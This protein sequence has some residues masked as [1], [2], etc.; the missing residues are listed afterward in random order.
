MQAYSDES[1]FEWIRSGRDAR[2]ARDEN[3][4]GNF[5]SLPLPKEFAAYVKIFHRID[6]S[7]EYMDNSLTPREEEIVQIPP[8]TELKTLIINLR[9]QHRG[10]RLKWKE[11]ADALGVPFE[12]EL[13]H[14]WY[15]A[16]L[17]PGCW[18][19]YLYGP[20]EGTL[21]SEECRAIVSDLR[22]LTGNQTCFFRFAEVPFVGTNKQLLFQG[23]LEE[24]E[25]FLNDSAYQFTPE[26]WWP[27]DRNWC[28]CT[29]Y[30]LTFTIVGGSEELIS[31]FLNDNFLEC[32]EVMPSTRID[33]Y[34]PMR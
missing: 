2:T 8:C 6:A 21:K 9:K 18:P 3:W 33:D 5:V 22:P 25:T 24:V 26:Y 29:D 28:L 32:I 30:D 7:Y 31:N 20:D 4:K 16:K 10:T 11:I 1:A 14:A 15:R 34:A 12:P 13:T 19:R 17:E 27:A 23:D